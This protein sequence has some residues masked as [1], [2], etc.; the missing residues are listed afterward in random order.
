MMTTI[1]PIT[2]KIKLGFSFINGKF[3]LYSKI[4]MLYKKFE[5]LTNPPS[6]RRVFELDYTQILKYIIARPIY[7]GRKN[8]IEDYK[9]N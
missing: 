7:T 5:P 4:G 6:I 9:L 1:I 2:K 8:E 3:T